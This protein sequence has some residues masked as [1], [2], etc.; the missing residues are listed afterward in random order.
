MAKYP[1]ES[2]IPGIVAMRVSIILFWFW[3]GAF[4][5]SAPLDLRGALETAQTANLELR[6]AR[7]NRALAIAGI[8]TARQL[9]NPTIS[10]TAA[11]D[12]PHEGVSFDLPVEL[13]NKRGKRIALAREEQKATEID[14]AV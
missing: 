5:Q 3:S 14:I 10:F 6:A 9:P 13:G 4:A 2:K 1:S 12:T 8:A 7:Q 11:R